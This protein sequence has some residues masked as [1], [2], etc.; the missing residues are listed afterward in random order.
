[1]KQSSNYRARDSEEN[2]YQVY[3]CAISCGPVG[4]DTNLK[5]EFLYNDL[6]KHKERNRPEEGI[7]LRQ[8]WKS[9]LRLSLYTTQGTVRTVTLFLVLKLY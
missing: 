4:S 5:C 2:G 3:W 8:N 7:L 1:M 9:F 6:R